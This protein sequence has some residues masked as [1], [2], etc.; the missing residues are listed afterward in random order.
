MKRSR[1]MLATLILTAVALTATV[2][3]DIMSNAAPITPL[4]LSL[5]TVPR[6]QYTGT[7]IPLKLT[8]Q[9]VSEERVRVL[10]Y[11]SN[12]TALPVFF[13]FDIKKGNGEVVFIPGAGKISFSR[14]HLKYI[15]LRKNDKFDLLIN[16]ADIVPSGSRLK[17]GNYT[18]SVSYH[19][20]YGDDCFK[21]RIASNSISLRIVG[22]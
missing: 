19:N 13:S 1:R 3:N 15:T 16:L 21:G 20:Q 2:R 10:N 17:R 5:S 11:F 7:N 6:T 14:D 22:E 18:I 9:N 12:P 4:K 8:F